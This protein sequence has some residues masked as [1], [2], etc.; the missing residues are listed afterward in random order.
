MNFSP[1]EILS[2]ITIQGIVIPHGICSNGKFLFVLT[3]D[4]LLSTFLIYKGMIYRRISSF[5]LSQNLEI[6]EKLSCFV[7]KDGSL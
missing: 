1:S 5:Q 2:A 7:L 3:S 4:H 6:S